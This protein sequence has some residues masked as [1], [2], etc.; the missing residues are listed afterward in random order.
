MSTTTS[1]AETVYCVR[2]L[3]IAKLAWLHYGGEVVF[4]GALLNH[5]YML[6]WKWT[7]KRDFDM[8]CRGVYPIDN[9]VLSISSCMVLPSRNLPLVLTSRPGILFSFHDSPTQDGRC[10]F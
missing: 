5:G 4:T 2:T 10:I 6:G 8:L 9:G 3:E 1:V 7:G